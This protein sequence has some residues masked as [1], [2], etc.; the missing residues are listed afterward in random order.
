[1]ANPIS[2]A[3][4]V[5]EGGGPASVYFDY[6]LGYQPTNRLVSSV[7]SRVR[8]TF[9][10]ESGVQLQDSDMI[11]WIN[12]AQATICNRNKVL[13]TRA[14]TW[15]QANIAEYQF[16]SED[17]EQIESLHY[18]GRILPNKSF[19]QAELQLQNAPDSTGEPWFWY[20]WG[21][22]FTLYPT[23]DSAKQLTIYYT[24][25]PDPISSVDDKLNVPDKYFVA[26]VNYVLAQAY[27]M[28][29]DWQASQAKLQQVE[30]SVAS[31]GEEERTAQRMTYEVITLID[32][33]C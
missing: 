28:D 13:K 2:G 31:F 14:F 20:E 3:D 25:Q 29:E 33:D 9:G 21:G 32:G 18:D 7:M 26:I 22:A 1:M 27:E 23:P 11:R 19:A 10:D 30:Q 12:D 8:R 6:Q 24:T 4:Q 17:I 16:P 5:V 15:T